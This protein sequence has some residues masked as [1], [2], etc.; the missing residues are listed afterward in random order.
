MPGAAGAQPEGAAQLVVVP[1]QHAPPAHAADGGGGEHCGGGLVHAALGVGEREHPGGAQVA[2]EHAGGPFQLLV[3]R[4]A[5]ATRRGPGSRVR[6]SPNRPP[7]PAV[8]R[9]VARAAVGRPAVR[10]AASAEVRQVPWAPDS[11]SPAGS[12]SPATRTGIPPAGRP[13]SRCPAGRSGTR[14][15]RPGAA[16]SPARPGNPGRRGTSTRPGSPAPS[17]TRARPDSPAQPDSP[18]PSGTPVRPDS[19]AQP[20]SPA[21]P[22]SPARRGTPARPGSP[23]PSGTPARPDSPAPPGSPARPGRRDRP[24][25]SPR[26]DRRAP[27]RTTARPDARWPAPARRNRSVRRAVAAGP[28]VRR[29]RGGRARPAPRP[30]HPAGRGPAMPATSAL[31]R[32]AGPSRSHCPPRPALPA[33]SISV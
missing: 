20:D 24:G 14:P 27:D 11:R 22:G 9:Q 25:R 31:V 3:G 26:P 21:R 1:G 4:P 23:A 16:A 18:A 13:G 2:T 5:D 10:R 7:G 30:G 8:A 17:G 29:R 33:P 12:R 28:E 15:A 19:P 6:R 32:P